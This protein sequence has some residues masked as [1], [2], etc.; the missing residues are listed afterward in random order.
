[1]FWH[2][3][4]FM[5]K[6]RLFTGLWRAS[7]WS[8]LQTY[9]TD[10]PQTT[11]LTPLNEWN[12]T[13]GKSPLHCFARYLLYAVYWPIE[14]CDLR[15]IFFYYYFY[16]LICQCLQMTVGL[17][18]HYGCISED[19]SSLWATV[20]AKILHIILHW[21]WGNVYLNESL[22]KDLNMCKGKQNMLHKRLNGNAE[23][24]KETLLHISS[25]LSLEISQSL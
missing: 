12:N 9:G 2:F 25:D 4:L 17:T 13:V 16:F 19:S 5:S 21:N 1:M 18:I 7:D 10:S 23:A 20:H 11:D 22:F 15:S 6:P 8:H 14:G 3:C 24:Q